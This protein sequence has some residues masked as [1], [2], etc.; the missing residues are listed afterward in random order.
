MVGL[1]AAGCGGDFD[2][3][4]VVPERGTLGRELYTLVCDRVGAQA[5]RE[6]VT[7]ASFHA[8]CHPD[9]KGGFADKVD[10]SALVALDPAAVNEAGR[11]VPI[12]QQRSRRAYRI[13]RVEALARR[14]DDLIH[15]LDAAFP[16]ETI[17]AKDLGNKD[18]AKSCEPTERAKLQKEMGD[19]LTRL[20]DLEN[21]GTLPLLTRA[22]GDV[23]EDIRLDPAAREALA[24]IDA[25]QGYRPANVALGAARPVF[26]YPRIVELTN[27]LLQLVSGDSDPLNGKIDPSKPL[28]D[29]NRRPIPGKAHGELQA[30]LRAAHEELRSAEST[31]APSVLSFGPDPLVPS[32]VV[33][34]RPRSSLELARTLLLRQDPAFDLGL[35]GP[36]DRHVTRRDGRGVAAVVMVGGKVPSPFV[37]L[38]GDQGSGPDGLPDLDLLG[39]FVTSAPITSPF[40]SAGPSGA[41]AGTRDPLGRALRE[42]GA[43]LFESV[44]TTRTFLGTL[45]RDL[46]PLLDPD[47]AKDSDALLDVLAAAPLVFGPRDATPTTSRSYPPDPSLPATWKLTHAGTPPATLGTTAVALPYKA[48][49]PEASPTVDLVHAV[50]QILANPA[51]DDMLELARRL[52]KD[53]PSEMARLIGLGLRIKQIADLHPEAKIPAASTL[54]DELLDTLAKIAHEPGILEDVVLAFKQDS[55]V[56]L[57]DT[58]ASYTEFRDTLTYDRGDLNGPARNLTTGAIT[59]L[60][61]PVD[62]TKPDVGENRSALQRFMQLLHDAN[63]LS[64]CTKEDAIVPI[65]WNGVKIHYPPQNAFETVTLGA[66]C[67]TF[68]GRPAPTRLAQCAVLRFE[69]VAALLLDVALGRAEF[70]VRDPCLKGIMGSP[71]TGIVGGVDA[72]LEEVSGIKGFS[73]HPTVN[74]VGRMVFFDSPHDGL[75]GDTQNAKTSKFLQGVLDPIPSMVCPSTPF[76]DKDGKVIP[77]RTCSTFADTLRGRDNDALFPIEQNDFI[78]NVQPLAAAFADHKQSLLFV[79]LFDAL[80]VHWGSKA[81]P[82]EQCDPSQPKTNARYCAQD[83]ASSY[84]AL[85]VHVLRETDLFKALQDTIPVLE[86]IKIAHCDAADSKT[87]RCTKVGATK[88]GV[89]VLVELTRV[90]L[91]P[92][93]NTGLRDPRGNAFAVRNDGTKNPQTTPIYLLIDAFK[94]VDAAFASHPDGKERQAEWRKARS[95]LVDTFF[96]VKGTG[97][98]TLWQN[99]STQAILPTL[100]ETLQSQL[101]ARCPDRSA[102]ASCVWARDELR[103]NLS[104]VVSGPTFAASL[105]LVEAFRKDDGARGELLAL[106]QY[107]LDPASVNDAHAT[108][109]AAL[110]DLLQVLSDEGNLA[111]VYRAIAGAA[112]TSV[113]NDQGKVVRRSLVD[114]LIEALTRVFAR[115]YDGKGNEVCR[116]EVDPNRVIATVLRKLVTPTAPD[117]LTPIEVLLSVVADVNRA[118]PSQTTKLDGADYENIAHE[119]NGFLLDKGSGLE[120]VY[121]VVR[122]AT[123]TP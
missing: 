34:S 89:Q 4:R 99:A 88:N 76:T 2:T 110:T 121:E 120:Q 48:F 24:R 57:Q 60:K 114:A 107:L 55:T 42:D 37:D 105:D 50:G 93:R 98:T 33:L 39:Q 15:A 19:V 87:G 49:H 14:R 51:T 85:L 103:K 112:G 92:A 3:R 17:P 96:S 102:G 6:D 16:E 52:A 58:F 97:K 68:S 29:E 82:R 78:K 36:R 67:L 41:S 116:R 74:G 53:H 65:D 20:K 104:D 115:V 100:V 25:R 61:T 91:D 28:S 26:A 40:Y 86:N 119:V 5:L 30:L 109:L 94:G 113:A 90:L 111:P 11:V 106:L 45:A 118:D 35:G 7:G 10:V 54:W 13:A 46:R 75:P 62:R 27:S 31:P 81:Q 18:P 9:P 80:H 101:V 56:K 123:K 122:Q 12:A 72:F 64:A 70:E 44:D 23:L 8:V 79:E 83:G 66:T 71:L 117:K 59:P 22:L 95:R 47:P 32:R 63:G 1:V 108:T 77:L 73:T 84:E 38:V 21:D 43:P 69:N